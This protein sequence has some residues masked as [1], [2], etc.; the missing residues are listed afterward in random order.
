V[1]KVTGMLVDLEC[2]GIG[3]IRHMIDSA[4]EL[5]SRVSEALEIITEQN[6]KMMEMGDLH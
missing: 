1:P 6:T 3:D 4:D 5:R 2:L